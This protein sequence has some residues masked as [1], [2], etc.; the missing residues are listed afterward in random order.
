MKTIIALT[1]F[2]PVSLNAVNYAADMACVIG[3][4]LSIMHV[5][6]LPLVFSEIPIP[7]YGIEGQI[8]EA[9]KK[10]GELEEQ[11]M[12][13]T[14][15]RIMVTTIVGQG[16]L[17]EQINSYCT[18]VNP[19]AVVMG[20]EDAG[21]IEK[22]LSGAKTLSAVT[23]LS[24]PLIVVPA[25]AK[26]SCIRKIGLA[27]DYKKVI[28]TI[29]FEEIKSLVKEFN[30]QLHVLYINTGEKGRYDVETVEES[31]WLQEILEKLNPVY[32]FIDNANIEKGINEFIEKESFDFLIIIPKKHNL[33]DK[34]FK[35]SH[36]KHL[37]L[38]AH[39]PVMSVH[40]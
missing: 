21:V 38:H 29:P 24:W 26:F 33:F 9:E 23:H 10:L 30:A 40:E 6:H 2:S 35:H 11:I 28:D 20:A 17:I 22:I 37:V 31:G 19:Y 39:V 15:D 34:I 7:Q 36:S 5:C 27:C 3:A 14:R 1:D 18:T 4:K 32:H 13:R 12:F 8:A 16:D 25:E